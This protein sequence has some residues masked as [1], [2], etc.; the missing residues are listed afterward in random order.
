[1]GAPAIQPRTGPSRW[2]LRLGKLFGIDV[3]VHA[4][5][6]FL[7]AW[8]A[9]AYLMPGRGAWVALG[10]VEFLLALFAIV[11]LHELAHALTARRFGI[12]TREI[13]L[14][15][16]GG[17]SRMDRMP[18][19]PSQELLV[20]VAGPA[21]NLAL[22]GV[23]LAALLAT[24]QARAALH[25]SVAEGPLLAKLMWAN[26]AL[27][28]F[29]LLPAFP[30]DGGRVLRSLLT[31]RMD[32]VKAT[33]AAAGVGQAAALLFGLVGLF[34]NPL[35]VFIALF[36]WVGAQEEARHAHVRASLEGVPV[37]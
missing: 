2:S 33:D 15:P 11:V 32:R 36:V 37:S 5:F 4:T 10:G 6:L 21:M 18:S 24:G 35:L 14:L 23:L 27:A 25:V 13:L 3:R 19:K 1:M 9:L 29:N 30:M 26:V 17:V 34:F 7:L 8:I 28:G 12:A 31:L 20:S 16:I 22:A